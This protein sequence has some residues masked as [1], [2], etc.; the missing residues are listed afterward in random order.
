[1]SL[2]L[3]KLR[4]ADYVIAGGTVLFF[5]LAF[6]PWF[7]LGEDA[8]G[9]FTLSGWDSGNV[10]TAFLLLLLAAAWTLLPAFADVQAGFPRSWI[11]VGLA[12]LAWLLTLF[13]WIRSFEGDFSVWA[14]LGFLTATGVLAFAVL[15]LLPELRNR[16]A[17][18]GGLANAAHWANQPAPDFGQQPGGQAHPGYGNPAPP[19]YS[20][21]PVPHAGGPGAAPPPSFPAQPPPPAPGASAPYSPP[22][23]AGGSTASGEGSTPD[24]R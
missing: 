11:T 4:M 18:P 21:P 5:V 13:A 1:L 19:Q 12:A 9:R 22:P 14:L 2:D 24:R 15:R 16:P 23:T 8:F 6:L 10:T 20:P 7:T 17:L 3:K